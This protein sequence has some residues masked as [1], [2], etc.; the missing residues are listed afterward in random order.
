MSIGSVCAGT[1]SLLASCAFHQTLRTQSKWLQILH[2]VSEGVVYLMSTELLLILLNKWWQQIVHL[3]C[4]VE[5]KPVKPVLPLG[6][7]KLQHVTDRQLH[8][9]VRRDPLTRD[10]GPVHWIKS[11]PNHGLTLC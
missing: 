7:P 1:N 4:L 9:R 8:R 2:R 11:K 6:A 10:P 3:K 5:R